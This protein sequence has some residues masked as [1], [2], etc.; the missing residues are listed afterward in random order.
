MARLVPARPGNGA[1]STA[2][3][4]D[5]LGHVDVL[6]GVPTELREE[7]AAGADPIELSAGEWLFRAGD[8]GSSAYVVRTGRLEV[9]AESGVVIGEVKR[10]GVIGELAL[11]R[12][13]ARAASVRARRDTELF[14]LNGETFARLLRD[15]PEFAVSL[16]R[17]L[18][19]QLA[20]TRPIAPPRASPVTIAV[21]ALDSGAPARQIT[22]RLAEGLGRYGSLAHLGDSEADRPSG[23]LPTMLESAERSHD[24]VLL[25][26]RGR[27]P[28]DAWNG[29]CL[30]E[31]DL[32]V[33]IGSGRPDAAWLGH[34]A[35]L[36][37]CELL[38]AGG[39]LPEDVLETLQP[40]EVHVRPSVDMLLETTDALARRLAGRS[41]GLV[42]SGGGARAFAHLGVVEVLRDAGLRFDRFA[43]VSLGSIV[44]GAMA[45]GF[46]L[47]AIYERFVQHFVAENP[48][49]DYTLPAVA[50]LRGRK[51]QRILKEVMGETHIEELPKSFFCLSCDLVA[52]KS[53]IHRT[54]LLRE[55]IYASLAIPGVFPPVA[56]GDGRLLVD[57]GVLDNLPV[58]TMSR[59]HE[60][61]VV[62]SDVTAHDGRWAQS[63]RSGPAKLNRL[64]VRTLTGTDQV[65]PRL[66]E[67]LLRTFTLGSAD[68][69]AAALAHADLVVRPPVG[70]VGLMDWKQLPR[71]REAGRA[72]A[73][74]VLEESPEA[75][76]AWTA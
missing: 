57:G 66:G 76:A 30:R 46:E 71:L 41:L 65:L 33:G 14:E 16:T 19:G 15:V 10:G 29:F 51:T 32:V 22:A 53:V 18:A 8:P 49:N 75:V 11:L 55:A 12:E 35:E 59:A 40:R 38:V 37:G 73:R 64:L 5:F 36:Q 45:M 74:A 47:E 2:T 1:S 61:P 28:D 68:T 42:L 13:E 43:G 48:S 31:A 58:E 52:R 50:V 25:E 9:I 56:P 34:A 3:L 63:R 39:L 44:A 27:L 60:G 23:D 24:R 4:A 62:A 54:G 72:A 21:V 70:G 67:T 20:A 17:E 7:L 69:A 26:G 6:A